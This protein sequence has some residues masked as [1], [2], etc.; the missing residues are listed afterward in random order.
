MSIETL[1]DI[2]EQ[3]ADWCDI[4]GAEK[5]SP[6]T[7]EIKSRILRAVEVEQR[8]GLIEKPWQREID[9]YYVEG[10]DATD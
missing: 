6:W 2:V 7:A 9:R 10:D 8:L 4:W 1:D 3:I 5:R